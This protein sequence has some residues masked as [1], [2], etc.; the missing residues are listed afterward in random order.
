LSSLYGQ[1]VIVLKVATVTYNIKLRDNGVLPAMYKTILIGQINVGGE[2]CTSLVTPLIFYTKILASR[3]RYSGPC[4]PGL[5]GLPSFVPTRLR[6]LPCRNICAF[7]V[8][9][10][11]TICEAFTK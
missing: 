5:R 11:R 2:I 9:F 3:S 1:D 4:S 10:M 6:G 8:S 7:F